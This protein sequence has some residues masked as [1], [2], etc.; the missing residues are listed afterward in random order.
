MISEVTTHTLATK[1][2]TRVTETTPQ[3]IPVTT[4]HE[5]IP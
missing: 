3:N 1:E 5:K 2:E 4:V